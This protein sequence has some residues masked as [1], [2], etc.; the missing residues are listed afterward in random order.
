M[1]RLYDDG[2]MLGNSSEVELACMRALGSNWQALKE[3][4]KVSPRNTAER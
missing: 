3:T 4:A 1:R 2:D